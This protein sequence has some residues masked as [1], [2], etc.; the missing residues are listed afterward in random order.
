MA[1][2]PEKCFMDHMFFSFSVTVSCFWMLGALELAMA[3]A[4]WTAAQV[5]HLRAAAEGPAGP[6]H[7][8]QVTAIAAPNPSMS[9]ASARS[10]ST[11]QARRGPLL[12]QL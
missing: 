3:Y 2:F 4:L 7:L 12:S 10:L 9:C 5:F 1:C 6:Q 11:F 8:S